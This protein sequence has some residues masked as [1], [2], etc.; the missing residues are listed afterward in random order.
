MEQKLKHLEF[1]QNIINRMA[2]NSFVIKG[3]TLLLVAAF[4]AFIAR[5][6]DANLMLIAAVPVIL[7]WALDGYYLH[8]ERLF[9]ALYNRVRELDESDIDFSMD[10]SELGGG[11]GLLGAVF[12]KTLLTYYLAILAI[13]ILGMLFAG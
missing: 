2:R 6:G 9:R 8:Q 5:I 7:F 12:S 4:L 3:W 11:G 1:I 13:L 10:T